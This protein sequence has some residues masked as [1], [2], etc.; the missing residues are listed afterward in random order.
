[1]PKL[2][3]IKDKY[4]NDIRVDKENDEVFFND[5]THTYY[6]KLNMSQYISVTSL[7]DKYRQGFD[8]EFWSKYKALEALMDGDVFSLIKGG[9]LSTK[10]FNFELINKYNINPTLFESKC[11]EIKQS[12]E[13][14]KNKACTRGNE[15]H[16]N[17]EN[18]FYGNK[19]FDFSKYGLSGVCG[20]FLCNKNY[21][22]LDLD[23]GVYPEF[24]ISKTFNN[25]LL[26]ISGQMDLLIIDHSDAY[27]LDWK[28][29]EE[30]KKTS[31]FDRGRKTHQMMKFPL[32]NIQDCNY[33][34]Y[35]LQLSTYAYL[36][37]QIRP[38]LNIGGL[39]IVH[40]DH[41]N[42]Q[43][44]YDVDYLKSDVERMLKHYEK[45]IKIQAELDL[46]KTIII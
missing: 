24:L 15:I 13:D 42:K 3:G 27:I 29:N 23:R 35:T 45:K 36:L 26:R 33:W 34:H 38:D 17:M 43:N 6:N 21:Y 18:G 11:N 37:Q 19:T 7:I 4:I 8:V 22:Q 5:D 9:L 12:Y 30:I 44:V 14:A 10:K 46:D 25:N 32:N 2:D 20:D 40:F 16:K 39:K 41:D 28:T 1:M 31:Y